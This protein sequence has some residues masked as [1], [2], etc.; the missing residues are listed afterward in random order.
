MSR[1]EN[2][3]FREQDLVTPKNSLIIPEK[4][5]E[6]T[7]VNIRFNKTR[8]LNLLSNVGTHSIH[9][10]SHEKMS[11]EIAPFFI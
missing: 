1:H 7:I 4:L 9:R 3:K 5:R 6:V 2:I 11:L 10:L 8:I